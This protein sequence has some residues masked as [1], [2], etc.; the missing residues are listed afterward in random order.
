MFQTRLNKDVLRNAPNWQVKPFSKMGEGEYVCV[1]VGIEL[2]T[3]HPLK[4][5]HVKST[6]V[7]LLVI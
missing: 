3:C 6:Y 2:N 1:K 7:L 4:P 5:S